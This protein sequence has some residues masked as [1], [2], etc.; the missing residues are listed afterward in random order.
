LPT[1]Q[2]EQGKIFLARNLHAVLTQILVKSADGRARKAIVEVM[3]NTHAIANLILTDKTY[4]IPSQIQ[5][6]REKG[7]QL[8]DQALMEALQR[9]DIDPDDVYLHALD[10]KLFQRFVTDPALLPKVNL[11]GN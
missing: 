5:T 6:G 9:K 4:Q 3:L 10:K 7:M 8:M 11:A 2:R 1:E